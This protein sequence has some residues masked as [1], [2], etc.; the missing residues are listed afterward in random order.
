MSAKRALEKY[1]L[2][3]VWKSLEKF[4]LIQVSTLGCQLPANLLH[5]APL[6]PHPSLRAGAVLSEGKKI[7]N[8]EETRVKMS[9]AG[10]NEERPEVEHQPL[11]SLSS[12]LDGAK[13][14]LANLRRKD[15]I[16]R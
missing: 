3:Q 6:Q 1:G 9:E 14:F 16:R 8:D 12:Q 13:I 15:E 5:T 2:I 4:G 10:K 7:H 11:R